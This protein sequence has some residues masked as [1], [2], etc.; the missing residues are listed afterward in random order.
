MLA[1]AYGITRIVIACGHTD[2]RLGI[3]GLS[4]IVGNNYSLN[5][6]EKNV[7]FLFCGRK[8]D[9]IKA[10]LWE[11]DGFL[12]LYKRLENGK[13]SWSKN[14]AEAADLTR[15]QYNLLMGGLNPLNPKIKEVSPKM[16]F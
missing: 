10:L 4:Q 3:E 2:L 7:L 12:L 6:F 13:F 14:Q 5:P 15:E 16:L 8:S 11:G 1:E 9:R